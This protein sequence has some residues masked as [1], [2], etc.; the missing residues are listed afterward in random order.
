M[1]SIY[2]SP[3]PTLPTISSDKL[4]SDK[5][6]Q[7]IFN[8][9]PD[10]IYV[11]DKN[12]DLT[13]FNKAFA[14]FFTKMYQKE[15]YI[16]K[17]MVESLMPT[18]WQLFYDRTLTGTSFEQELCWSLPSHK[19]IYVLAYFSPIYTECQEVCG[20]LV[21]LKDS[22]AQHL[23][24]LDLE[25]KVQ[26]YQ[27]L[28]QN[29]F[30]G[31]FMYDI[32]QRKVLT[33]NEKLQ[34]Y[35][36]CSKYDFVQAQPTSFM[37]TQ[38]LSGQYSIMAWESLLRKAP[39]RG[40]QHSHWLW[41]N[42][43]GELLHT[44]ATYM[45]LPYPKQNILVSIFKDI[46]QQQAIEKK[47]LQVYREQKVILDAIPA[48]FL[49]KDTENKIIR[50]NQTVAQFLGYQTAEELEGKNLWD[51]S[52]EMAEQIATGDQYVLQT[53][54]PLLNQIET[55]TFQK[56]QRWVRIDRTPYMNGKG[57]V[58]GVLFYAID[59]TALKKTQEAL[60]RKNVQLQKYIDSNLELENFAYVASHDLKEPL[61]TLS[62]FAQLLTKKYADKL[63]EEGVE[64]LNYIMTA[65]QNMNQLISDLLAYSRVNT[66]QHTVEEINFDRLINHIIQ[67]LHQ[68]IQ[69]KSAVLQL[70]QL[71]S[72]V[73][74]NSTK[75]KQLFQNLMANAI[76][77][78]HPDRDPV[79]DIS[80]KESKQ[81]WTFCISDNGIGIPQEYHEKI[82][83]L[84]KKLH[85]K[86]EYE[87]TGIGLA[88][89]QKIV[90]QHGGEIWV[91]SVLNEGT[92]FFF[93]LHKEGR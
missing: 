7:A 55:Y 5:L 23:T 10:F 93:T 56:Q 35:L 18:H 52:S 24:S 32:Y 70:D 22:T 19:E 14:H 89:C 85:N 90:Q 6:L 39:R 48:F 1:T 72:V 41:E 13:L 73:Y 37:P 53:G 91:E 65:T 78:R 76:K 31:I 63:D 64:F 69:D 11:I 71:P 84:F 38:Q 81:Y 43:E 20:C 17:K 3:P 30:D 33:I 75:I 28:F 61:R 74:G 45:T 16:G 29:I 21:Q 54:E 57:E 9:T 88:I 26:Q 50:C 34:Q 27:L 36:G 49:H 46:T 44:D 15:L 68:S 25:Q 83:L 87:G 4:K 12:Y 58:T 40:V 77:F 59:I 67:S 8:A 47:Q 60:E 42:K 86:S 51:I 82:F 79:V 66:K 2:Q 92:T 80:C 62:G